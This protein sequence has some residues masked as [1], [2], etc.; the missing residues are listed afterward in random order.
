MTMR[1]E[2]ETTAE[3]W[4]KAE[5]TARLNPRDSWYDKIGRVYYDDMF[6]GTIRVFVDDVLVLPYWER[7]GVRDTELQTDLAHAAHTLNWLA[8]ALPTGP[9]GT[10]LEWAPADDGPFLT[11]RKKGDSVYAYNQTKSPPVF[12]VQLAEFQQAVT[13]YVEEFVG[14]L[15][16]E[17]P[18][19]LSWKKLER[20]LPFASPFIRS[21]IARTTAR[22]LPSDDGPEPS[23]TPKLHRSGTLEL[24]WHPHEI[25]WPRA[26][27]E[28]ALNLPGSYFDL[29]IQAQ[30][31][32]FVAPLRWTVEGRSLRFYDPIGWSYGVRAG[33]VLE[34]IGY[35]WPRPGKPGSW[36]I[37]WPL[38]GIALQ[39]ARRAHPEDFAAPDVAIPPVTLRDIAERLTN[40]GKPRV[41]TDV[42]RT[43]KESADAGYSVEHIQFGSTRR[44]ETAMRRRV[45]KEIIALAGEE[46][47]DAVMNQFLYAFAETVAIYAPQAFDWESF[48]V[49]RRYAKLA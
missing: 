21:D 18:S 48:S 15:E 28:R 22:D 38:L 19:S 35:R 9:D 5:E 7:D 6:Q 24:E 41:G 16:R 30:K 39:A 20:L 47:F 49:L 45:I 40:L 3:S 17:A 37:P 27:A 8:N 2:W 13:V 42:S 4:T 43:S 36:N 46:H 33:E 23:L 11:F 12:T 25:D 32:L 44:C 31:E 34:I 10:N 14:D 1:F 29:E 26:R